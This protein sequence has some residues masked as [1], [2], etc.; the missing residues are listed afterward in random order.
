MHRFGWLI[1]V[2]L[3]SLTALAPVGLCPCWLVADVRTF[4]PHPDGHPERPHGHGYLFEMFDAQSVAI[5][6]VALI[7]AHELVRLLAQD[8]LWQ[9]VIGLTL[10]AAGWIPPPFEPP[11]RIFLP[12]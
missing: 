12:S 4:H 11:P 1:L 10:G 5:V 3:V 6:A 9:Q 8:S 7:P 2:T